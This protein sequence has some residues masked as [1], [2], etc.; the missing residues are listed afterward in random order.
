LRAAVARYGE[1]LIED[2]PTPSP[3]V[4]E[5]LVRPLS[6]GICGSD[7]HAL[8]AQKNLGAPG[9]EGTTPPGV[10]LG[11]EFCFEIVD[12]GARSETVI[13]VGQA[14]TAMPFVLGDDG[15]S[16]VLGLTPGRP[17]GLSELM[18]LPSEALVEVPLDVDPH[19]VALAEPLAVGIRAVA[20]AQRDGGT[21]PY[22][23]LGCG[24]IGIAVIL[25]LRAQGLGPIV[26]SD[27]S[28]TR[29]ALAEQIGS[30]IVLDPSSPVYEEWAKLGASGGLPSP[31]IDEGSPPTR[32]TVFEC[33]GIPGILASII[34]GA[35]PH[36]QIISVSGCIQPD[37][38]LPVTAL[39]KELTVHFALAYRPSEFVESLRRITSKAIDVEPLISAKMGL[40]DVSEAVAALRSGLHNKILI[41]P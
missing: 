8:E 6:V 35:A 37:T 36:S 25:A 30:D 2:L 5:V 18:V 38:F 24:P 28:P 19:H 39:V 20:C 7:L 23:V 29:R 3:G 4:G 15:S 32:A 26:A 9:G 17:G 41:K 40:G 12:F 14:A 1:I 11:H 13:K 27:L 21:G 10:V 31:L 22:L 33:V 16:E 34:N